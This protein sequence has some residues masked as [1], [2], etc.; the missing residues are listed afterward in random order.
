MPEARVS[1]PSAPF[2]GAATDVGAPRFVLR[3]A[4]DAAPGVIAVMAVA[5]IAA[6]VLPAA[7]A[8]VAR[9]VVDTVLAALAGGDTAWR[10]E[11]ETVVLFV[12]LEGSLAVLLLGAQRALATCQALLRTRIGNRVAERILTKASTLALA[13]FEDADVHDRMLRARRE[14][15]SRPVDLLASYFTLARLGVMLAS[16]IVLLTPLSWWAAAIVIFAGLPAF[17][18]EMRFSAQAWEEQRKRSPDYRMHAYLETLLARE[19]FATEMKTNA[20]SELFLGRFRTLS[21]RIEREGAGVALERGVAG[22]VLNGL[23]TALFYLGYAWI[24]RR[25]INEHL[26]VGEM[27]MYLALFRQAQSGVSGALTT[28][29]TVLDH[30]LYIADLRAFLALP[31]PDAS[32]TATEGTHPAQ[33]LVFEN[34]TFT[35]PGSSR[36]ALRGVSFELRPGEMVALVGENGSGKS[37][38]LKLAMRLYEPQGGSIR[39]DGRDVREWSPAALRRRFALVLQDFVRFKLSAGEN[40]GVGDVG[41][42]DDEARV[43]DAAE[44]GLSAEVIEALPEKYRTQLGKWFRGGVE[45]SGGQWQKVALSRAFMRSDARVLVLDEPSAS[46]DPEAEA[47]LF[48]EV[49]E[50]THGKLA[51][52][53]TA[54]DRPMVLLVSHRFGTVRSAERIVVLDGGAV[55]EEGTHAELMQ[56]AGHYAHLY[57]L[58]A[59]GSREAPRGAPCSRWRGTPRSGAGPGRCPPTAGSARGAPPGPGRARRRPTATPSRDGRGRSR[60]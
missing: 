34:V 43:R 19:D 12:G 46:L 48:D 29:G 5:T 35:Y 26:S 40:I 7:I 31:V 20:L 55:I 8:Y 13:Q 54:Q 1:D 60:A 47:Q 24:V 9:L 50:A 42:I 33:G 38:L 36:P 21:R 10:D 14:A 52:T 44:R 27:T 11:R 51:P 23:G 57:T 39:L 58:Q 4:I 30:H 25:T 37:T 17:I 2:S 59:A 45:L 18:A 6:G 28:M 53:E 56:R 32:G 3:L 16:C 22:F 41:H 49:H 15:E